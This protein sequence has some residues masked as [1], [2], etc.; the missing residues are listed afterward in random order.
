MFKRTEFW[1][2]AKVLL[3][4]KRQLGLA[5]V[6]VIISS[7]SFAAGLG[8]MLPIL[9]LFFRDQ[10]TLPQVVMEMMG[11]PGHPE[12][13]RNFA[14]TL[15]AHL[16]DDRF[17]G[18]VLTAGL[19]CVLT[20]IGS[21]GRYLH[22]YLAITVAY[23]GAM[24][25]RDRLFCRLVMAPVPFLS[26][27]GVA[28][29]QS[30]VLLDSY[31]LTQ[32][33][34]SILGKSVELLSK[35]LGALAVA[36]FFSPMLTLM[37]LAGAP[38]IALLLTRFGKIIRRASHQALRQ[39]GRLMAALNESLSAMAVVKVHDAEGYERRRFR[40]L[41]KLVYREQMR[42][43]RTKA[44]S[45]PLIETL[46]IYGA[47]IIAIVAA[48]FVFRAPRAVDPERLLVT[49]GALIAAGVTA[50]PLTNLHNDLKEADAAAGRV[51]EAM[52][53]PVEPILP[54]ERTEHPNL[55][56]HQREV[57]FEGV[58]YRYPGQE[59]QA[60]GGVDLR[61]EHGKTV[62][63]VG[64]NG[65]GKTTLLSTL[66]RLIEPEAG[67]VRIDGV[68]IRGVNLRSLRRQIGVVSQQS[69]LFAGS[70]ADNIRY[71]R[72]EESMDRVVSAAKLSMAHEFIQDLPQGYD[73]RLGED[74]VGLSGGQRQRI[75][76]ARAIL[77]DPSILILDEA[78]S[79]IDADSEAKINQAIR[80]V[81]Q[82][83]TTFVIAHR[84]STVV[85]A[86][87]IVLM[88]YGRIADMGRHSEL[89]ERCRSYRVLTQTQLAPVGA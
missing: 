78:T 60:L 89:L 32:S 67:R 29:Y 56:R 74:G 79:Q 26:S 84:L 72:R 5:L 75:C 48:W 46:A 66:T 39:H 63:I 25:W 42:M 68:D 33:Y 15:A 45:S 59:S 55:A 88:E 82:G 11:K 7:A 40:V 50:K 80:R 19:M 41:N 87:L 23:R 81:R 4:Y 52:T 21:L 28:D 76:I 73:T 53:I 38:P 61:V 44:F 70:I 31:V 51:L 9:K 27:K 20:T 16:P 10:M 85:D 30:R 47:M 54:V 22:E 71:G 65:S 36:F 24:I 69:V 37:A 83:R 77:R 1:T 43:R 58:T 6:G 34:Q 86:D 14:Q 57:T 62:A 18:F 8:M 17:W 49:I 35:G 3:N 2:S 13:V 64:G 12:A